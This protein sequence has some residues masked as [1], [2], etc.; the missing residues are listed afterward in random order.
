METS[1]PRC[2]HHAKI[3]DDIRARDL[4]LEEWRTIRRRAEEALRKSPAA[5]LSATI[6]LVS[7]GHIRIEDII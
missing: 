1:C 5:L 6:I 4:T 3:T 2:I 7:E